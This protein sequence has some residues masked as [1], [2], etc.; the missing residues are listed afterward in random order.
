MARRKRTEELKDNRVI[1]IETA[2][3]KKRKK[4]AQLQ[5]EKDKVSRRKQAKVF[6]RRL[7]Y[8]GIFVIIVLIIGASVYNVL[9]LKFEEAR[10][11]SELESLYSEKERL[12]EE[13]SHVDSKE[14]IEQ[15]ARD[16]L[17]MI[18]PGEVLYVITEEDD[19][20]D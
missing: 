12:E 9:S 7:I 18:Y 1:D 8:G 2:R 3:I 16:E 14:Y 10:A 5:E 6:R 19:N 17:R 11:I 20:E 13:L 15:Q 4:R